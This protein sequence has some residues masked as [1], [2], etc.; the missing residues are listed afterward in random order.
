MHRG[1]MRRVFGPRQVDIQRRLEVHK[2][3]CVYVC[4]CPWGSVSTI[5]DQWARVW[6]RRQGWPPRLVAR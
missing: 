6:R 2:Y 4:A 3:V 5:A 1:G